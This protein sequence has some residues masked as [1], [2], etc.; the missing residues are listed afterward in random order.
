MQITSETWQGTARRRILIVESQTL[1]GKGLSALLASDPDL[2]VIGDIQSL[3]EL[4]SCQPP[5]DVI[6]LDLDNHEGSIRQLADFVRASC[7][8]THLCV[9]AASLTSGDIERCLDAG[10][11]GLVVKDALPVEFIRATKMVAQGEVYVDPRVAGAILRR[12]LPADITPAELTV[13][14]T[15]IVRLIADGLSN[16]EI[17]AR[18]SL[19]E[20]T[21][22]SHLGRIF[23]KLKISGRTSAAVHAIK[24]GL[25]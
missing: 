23:S 15:E 16:K 4:A 11:E 13:R 8:S 25:A 9:I 3:A 12:R 21:V 17:G 19:S 1:F 6:V 18:L 7:A 20:K 5:P 24:A 14:E 10:V 2:E 22:K